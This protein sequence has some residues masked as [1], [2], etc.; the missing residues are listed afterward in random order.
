M[1]EGLYTRW[2][3][4]VDTRSLGDVAAPASQY[5][6]ELEEVTVHGKRYD[7]WPTL[8]VMGTLALILALEMEK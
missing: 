1:K 4:G 5:D 8:I 7:P 6:D 3:T 2:G